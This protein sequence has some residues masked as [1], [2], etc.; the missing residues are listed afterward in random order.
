[1]SGIIL[2]KVTQPT[3]AGKDHDK[4]D[5]HDREPMIFFKFSIRDEML[6]EVQTRKNS[7]TIWKHLK[8]MHET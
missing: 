8:D 3:V 4:F 7:A 5:G 6:P 2:R 1:L